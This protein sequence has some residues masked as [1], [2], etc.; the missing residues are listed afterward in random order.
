VIVVWLPLQ[1]A[2]CQELRRTDGKSKT[3]DWIVVVILAFLYVSCILTNIMTIFPSTSCY[4]IAG[5]SA[6]SKSAIR[7]RLRRAARSLVK[8]QHAMSL[9]TQWIY[10][11][12]SPGLS[13][14]SCLSTYRTRCGSACRPPTARRCPNEAYRRTE[15][16]SAWISASG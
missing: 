10:F 12:G 8:A 13:P 16:V 5:G 14:S 11:R 3:V 4:M 7:M 6:C 2:E 15:L 9:I 1:K